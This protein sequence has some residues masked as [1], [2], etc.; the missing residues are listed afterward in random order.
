MA[1]VGRS[2]MFLPKQFAINP[3]FWGIFL[4]GLVARV[5][6]FT[7]SVPASLNQDEAAILANARFLVEEGKDEWGQSWPVSF[8]SFG[9]AKLPGYIYTVALVGKV[10]GFSHVAVRLPSFIAGIALTWFIARLAAQLT[11][12]KD[13]SL[14]SVVLLLFSP[15]SWHYGSIGFE[16]NLSLALWV[17]GL[18]LMLGK[19]SKV[20]IGSV[21]LIAA[22]LTYNA[23]LLLLP[24][25]LA[26]VWLRDWRNWRLIFK[27]TLAIILAGAVAA[28]LTLSA[29]L[30]KGGISIF[31][32]P[33]FINDYP[34]FRASFG[35]SLFQTLFGNK[36]AYYFVIFMKNWLSHF[37]WDFLVMK[38]GEN[39]WHTM[40]LLGHFHFLV[41]VLFIFGLGASLV[42]L[43]IS[44]KQGNWQRFRHE[45]A[46]LVL[47][48]WSLVPAS[49]TADAPHATRSLFFFILL[50]IISA[51]GLIAVQNSYCGSV[52]PKRLQDMFTALLA[53]LLAIGFVWWWV[54]AQTRWKTRPAQRWNVG[55]AEVVGDERVDRSEKVYI[56]DPHGVLYAVVLAEKKIPASDFLSS[57][58]RSAPDTAGLVRVERFGGYV[59]IFQ[60]SDAKSPGLLLLPRTATRWDII[61]L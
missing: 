17:A 22:I 41:P 42:L 44:I 55:L 25:A 43:L 6:F 28:G 24:S 27:K 29:S 5:F 51:R 21:F 59:F 49:I 4:L 33:T 15:W 45:L 53:A 12:S 54:P 13:A 14:A 34:L 8:R 1:P 23:P 18:L 16:A 30:Q 61:E 38:G 20:F 57:V 56:V 40:P 11:D 39:P 7:F 32:D 46:L 47:L 36:F 2:G 58:Q 50:T 19:K 26:A 60:P 10:V 3:V 37:S 9:D 31:Q 35:Q 52:L 48:I